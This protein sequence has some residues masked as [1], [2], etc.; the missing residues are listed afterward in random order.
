VPGQALTETTPVVLAARFHS[1]TGQHFAILALFAIGCPVVIWLGR[2]Q[3]G[4]VT[5][6]RSRRLFAGAILVVAIPLQILQ[7]LPADWD[8]GTSLPFALCDLAWVAS[9]YALWTRSWWAVALPF[10]WGITLTSQGII[11]PSLG[12]TFP[13]PRFFG[14]WAHHF[15]VVWAALYLTWGLGLRPTWRGYRLTV[16]A[17]AVW[18]AAAYAFNVIA[19]TNYG[20]VNHKPSSASILDLLGPWPWYVLAEIAIVIV[21]WAA[22]TWPWAAVQRSSSA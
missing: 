19:D 22:M 10:Y 9:A 20:Y 16:I 1:V 13:D 5:E 17:T 2:R 6:A 12:E 4:S 8:L 18:A 3:R 15:L 21:L 7:F 14:F 11:T